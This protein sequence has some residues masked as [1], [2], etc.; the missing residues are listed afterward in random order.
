MK[1]LK[2]MIAIVIMLL[3]VVLIAENLAALSTTVVFRIV[4]FSFRI[5]TADMP[6]YYVLPIAF[7]FG[8][9]I[10]GVY[11]IRERFHLSKQIKTLMAESRAKDKELNSLRNL[12]ITSDDMGPNGFHSDQM[13]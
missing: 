12:P 8:V 9:L 4:F 10:T 5:E 1:H 11:G 6:L 7:L 3:V 13:E 2:F